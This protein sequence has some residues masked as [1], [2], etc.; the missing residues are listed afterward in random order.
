MRERDIRCNNYFHGRA[1]RDGA[2]SAAAQGHTYNEAPSFVRVDAAASIGPE[3]RADGT[4][5]AA[6][7]CV[8]VNAKEVR[9][10]GGKT[11][12]TR[13]AISVAID[14]RFVLALVILVLAL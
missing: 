14:W 1:G 6:T 9:A 7:T 2:H 10:M 4:Q 5:A 13:V 3:H 8:A 12:W 11:S